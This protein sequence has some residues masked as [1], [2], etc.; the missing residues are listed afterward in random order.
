MR[1]SALE[2]LS[3]LPLLLYVYIAVAHQSSRASFVAA[4]AKP[5]MDDRVSIPAS[6]VPPNR[7][8]A[9]KAKSNAQDQDRSL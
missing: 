3:S 9:V 1:H 8:I 6:G 2:Y 7:P 4:H 5:L